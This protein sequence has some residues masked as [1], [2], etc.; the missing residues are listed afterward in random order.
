MMTANLVILSEEREKKAVQDQEALVD[1]LKK[2]LAAAENGELKGVC[3]ATVNTG[4]ELTFGILSSPNCG[5]HELV[6]V[7]QMLNFRL[8]RAAAVARFRI[9]VCHPANNRGTLG[10]ILR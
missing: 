2:L 4:D 3:Y 10:I 1:G 9:V 6:G 7:S 8:V 5:I